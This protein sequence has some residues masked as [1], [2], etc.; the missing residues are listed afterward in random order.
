M[1]C[2]FYYLL[3]ITLSVSGLCS[4]SAGT[5]FYVLCVC[6][7]IEY[8]PF[9]FGSNDS[10]KR[11]IRSVSYDFSA[12]LF[13]SVFLHTY[14]TC[15][16]RLSTLPSA[17]KVFLP[18][19]LPFTPPLDPYPSSLLFS[20]P[21]LWRLLQVKVDCATFFL[22]SPRLLRMSALPCIYPPPLLPPPPT[23]RLSYNQYRPG[24][25]YFPWYFFSAVFNP[26]F[27]FLDK[28]MYHQLQPK[29]RFFPNFRGCKTDLSSIRCSSFQFFYFLSWIIFISFKTQTYIRTFFFFGSTTTTFIFCL[30]FRWFSLPLSLSL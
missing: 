9:L 6:F 2:L 22:L 8:S 11:C 17:F 4:Y 13:L 30:W 3:S 10:L 24:I 15:L 5:L 29:L 1:D 20:L 27:T 28:V 12:C 21:S 14:V 16:L 23:S 26:N 25:Q 19:F 7:F 18:P